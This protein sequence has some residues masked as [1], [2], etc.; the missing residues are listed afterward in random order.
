MVA[1]IE[2]LNETTV[3]ATTVAK[4]F[5][6]TSSL[7]VGVARVGGAV[8]NTLKGYASVPRLQIIYEK[9]DIW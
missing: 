8:K 1:F 7:K 2:W 4:F 9:S 5:K 3:K 6:P